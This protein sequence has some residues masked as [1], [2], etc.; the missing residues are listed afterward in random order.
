M[1]P[2]VTNTCMCDKI[3]K[4]KR[5]ADTDFRPGFVLK[6]EKKANMKNGLT[7]AIFVILT[8]FKISEIKIAVIN[9]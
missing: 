3:V 9:H 1:L 2:I 7:I 4:H 8:I 5:E 6:R